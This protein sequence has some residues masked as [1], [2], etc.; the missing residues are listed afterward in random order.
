MEFLAEKGVIVE[1]V[2]RCPKCGNTYTNADW[3]CPPQIK[4]KECGETM[5]KAA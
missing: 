3:R 4:C 1:E 2:Y 5:K